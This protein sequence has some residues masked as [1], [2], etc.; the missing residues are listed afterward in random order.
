[1]RAVQARVRQ[2]FSRDALVS[3]LKSLPWVVPM[4]VLI[5]VYAEREQTTKLPLDFRIVAKNTDSNR[6]GFVELSV[7]GADGRPTSSFV[8]H[9]DLSG[10][11]GRQQQ[12]KERLEAAGGVLQIDIHNVEPG[13]AQKLSTS[14]LLALASDPDLLFEKNGQTITN[15]TPRQVDVF[16]DPVEHREVKLA[17]RPSVM[18]FLEGP[19]WFDHQSVTITGPKSVLDAAIAQA[20]LA[21]YA[22][23][24]AGQT[25]GMKSQSVPVQ[26]SITD[27]RVTVSPPVVTARFTVKES[28]VSG[29][30]PSVSFWVS[31]PSDTPDKK[32]DKYKVVYY[33]EKDTPSTVIFNVPVIGPADIVSKIIDRSSEPPPKVNLDLST[34]HPTI[35]DNPTG[36]EYEGVIHYDFGNSAVRP[37]PGAPT[38]IKFKV[39]ERK[40]E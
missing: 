23:V 12:V 1:M 9:V 29:I 5:W 30:V 15:L 39:V 27:P 16:V 11:Q 22:D 25:P 17:V 40:S 4:T 37:G 8:V 3:G 6:F 7:P 10:P 32:W 35:G 38:S 14:D 20:T 26:A 13:R 33:P 2:L 36:I 19:P 34:A 28:E 21:A 24:K 31:Y 18:G